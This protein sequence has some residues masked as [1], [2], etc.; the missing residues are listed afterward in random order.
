MREC[1]VL[2]EFCVHYYEDGH[3][4][5]IPTWLKMKFIPSRVEAIGG[6]CC[7]KGGLDDDDG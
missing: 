6:G 2:T 4:Y 7:M 1:D 3:K 5:T